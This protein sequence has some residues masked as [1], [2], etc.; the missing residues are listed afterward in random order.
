MKIHHIDLKMQ[1]IIPENKSNPEE[2]IRSIKKA[3]AK[4][5]AVTFQYNNARETLYYNP[6]NEHSSTISPHAC[7][8]IG[9][10]DN[11]PSDKFVPNG[12]T[13]GGWLV[14]TVTNHWSIFG[15]HMTIQAVVL[16][17]FHL[18]QRTSMTLIITMME[19]W[20]ISH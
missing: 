12:A 9:W 7:I 20:T 17:H 5:G 15:C 4:Y 3:I 13:K 11:I 18:H 2:Y 6:K 8:I 14:K 19:A 16:M 1:F 10:D